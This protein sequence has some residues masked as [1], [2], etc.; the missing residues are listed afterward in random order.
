MKEGS[1]NREAARKL[2]KWNNR[3]IE[4]VS[5]DNIAVMNI[6]EIQAILNEDIDLIFDALVIG[7]YIED[8]EE[9]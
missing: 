8:E 4:E 1:H 2:P 3:A 6:A 5:E 7:D 9:A